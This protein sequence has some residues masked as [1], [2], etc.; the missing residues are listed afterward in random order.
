MT[1]RPPPKQSQWQRSVQATQPLKPREEADAEGRQDEREQQMQPAPEVEVG[2][3]G[4]QPATPTIGGP[5][6][7]R[8]AIHAAEQ[9]MPHF[10]NRCPGSGGSTTELILGCCEVEDR[11]R[12]GNTK[13]MQLEADISNGSGRLSISRSHFG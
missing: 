7:A 10:Q 2:Q 9:T 3:Q 5:Q 4:S 11:R 13:C 8:P 12:V 1:I 6:N